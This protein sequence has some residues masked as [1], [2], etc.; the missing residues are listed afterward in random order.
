MARDHSLRRILFGATEFREQEGE[1]DVEQETTQSQ[2]I[3]YDE[4]F[5]EEKMTCCFVTGTLLRDVVGIPV[6]VLLAHVYILLFGS[7]YMIMYVLTVSGKRAGVLSTYNSSSSAASVN[8]S[9]ICRRQR[10]TFQVIVQYTVDS[11]T[12]K[13]LFRLKT[14][15]E[16]ESIPDDP[17][18]RVLMDRPASAELKCLIDKRQEEE[19]RDVTKKTVG[20]LLGILF[21]LLPTSFFV[22][23]FMGSSPASTG[24]IYSVDGRRVA[25]VAGICIGLNVILGYI[26]AN[27]HYR[28]FFLRNLFYGAKEISLSDAD[29]ASLALDE[30]ECAPVPELEMSTA[31]KTTT[32]SD[33]SCEFV[34]A[35]LKGKFPRME[36]AF[37]N[38][39]GLV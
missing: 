5:K 9:V 19:E 21:I 31:T 37:E 22:D 20:G 38:S 27:I 13:K 7:G 34:N 24:N 35:F 39:P 3:S 26:G 32:S 29:Q 12:F 18:L 28:F 1:D 4:L 15:E 23:F 30:E 14:L 16:C 36:K 10:F 17:E 33:E 25:I 8:G 11:K 2:N 6:S